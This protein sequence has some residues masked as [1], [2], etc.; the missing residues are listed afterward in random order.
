MV[1]QVNKSMR[2]LDYEIMEL[3]YKEFSDLETTVNA[4][5]NK[6]NK[7]NNKFD[8]SCIM[9]EAIPLLKFLTIETLSNYHYKNKGTIADKILTFSTTAANYIK[10]IEEATNN[11]YC[12]DAAD[13]LYQR[14]LDYS[15]LEKGRFSPI[16][17]W[18][19]P[20]RFIYTSEYKYL[21]CVMFG[22]L[23]LAFIHKKEIPGLVDI[24]KQIVFG[25]QYFLF[26]QNL[27]TI[28]SDHILAYLSSLTNLIKNSPRTEEATD[29]NIKPAEIVIDNVIE[30]K[31]TKSKISKLSCIAVLAIFI[32][33]CFLSF[34]IGTYSEPFFGGTKNAD[35]SYVEDYDSYNEEKADSIFEDYVYVVE[36]GECYHSNSSCSNMSYPSKVTKDEAIDQGYRACKKC[37]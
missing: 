25:S 27:F 12:F 16:G 14:S 23:S 24:S 36:D 9:I 35:T 34:V 30:P 10:K 28:I 33:F 21:A 11:T 5:F 18:S 19:P 22:D 29:P 6:Q 4:Y 15:T 13:F 2:N 32:L 26:Y 8:T 7:S 20:N 3:F 1:T 17:S 37:Y 31:N